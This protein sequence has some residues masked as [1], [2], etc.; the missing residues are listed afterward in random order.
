VERKKGGKG[1]IKGEKVTCPEKVNRR[2]RY[3]PIS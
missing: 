3:L 2:N 1:G